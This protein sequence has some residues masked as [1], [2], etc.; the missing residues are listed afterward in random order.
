VNESRPR[1]AVVAPLYG[2]S[3]L[4][5][6]AVYAAGVAKQL[7]AS[8]QVEVLTT[9]ADSYTTWAN[10]MPEGHERVDGVH[11]RRF[12]VGS[13]RDSRGF[14][15]LSQTL[16][17]DPQPSLDLQ[18]SWMRA[19]GPMAEGLLEHLDRFANRYDAV[20]FVSYL[21]AITYFGLPIVED[22][23]LLVPLAHDEWPIRFSMW[24]RFFERPRSFAFASTEERDFLAS[25]F[26]HA[27]L[28]GPI[29]GAGIVSPPDID[30][31]RFRSAFGLEDRFVLYV[32]RVDASKGCETLL[33]DFARH[34]GESG[35]DRKLVMVGDVHM[36]LPHPDWLVSTGRVSERMKWDA[37]AAAD[38]V[39]VPSRY[40]SLSI[41]CLEAWACGKPTLVNARSTPL[42]GQCRRSGGGLWY[43]NADEFTAALQILDHGEAAARLGAQGRRYVTEYYSWQ[44]TGASIASCLR[45]ICLGSSSQ[46]S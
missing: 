31:Q 46:A 2:E 42:V 40:E 10:A 3:W 35:T 39:V 30:A 22:R 8:A 36:A 23:A 1:Y 34:R 32:G 38:S 27:R 33:D 26:R 7:T 19:Q 41:A 6:S 29:A 44:K 16:L 11:V 28:D 4:G 14:D 21:Y 45:R 18:E 37:L 12:P 5:G 17:R 15:R 13:S 25:R 9:C 43:S 24:D 20:V